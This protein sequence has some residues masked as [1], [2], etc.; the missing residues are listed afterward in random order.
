M[1]S[2]WNSPSY[3]A[4]STAS[5]MSTPTPYLQLRHLLSLTWLAY[6]ILSLIFIAFRLQ[7]SL[8]D[9]QNSIASAK[10]TLIASC[11]A[12]EEAATSA[13]SMPRFLALA[14]NKQ[15]ADAVNGSLNAARAALILSLTVMEAVINF[16]IDLYRSTFLCFVELVVKGALALV[17]A[18]VEE[19]NKVVGTIADGLATAIDTVLNPIINALNK[20]G[21][22]AAK[23]V[24]ID[25]NAIK[26]PNLDALH[27]VSLP[28]SFM[29][30][31]TKLSD[32]IPSV[33]DLKDKIED[34]IDTP[35]ELL[36]KDVND[37]FS[38]ISFDPDG[39]PVPEVA[40]VT[41]CGDL[42]TSV[43]D[44]LGRDL[45]K[46][47]KI[48]VVIII[49]LAL[50]L[51]ALNC[52][53]TWYK[54][55]C[56]RQHLQY[57]R[58]AWM[59]DP[60]IVHANSAS[61]PPQIVMSDHNLLMLHANSEHP[62]ITRITNVL[63][64]RLRLTPNNHA[65][66]QWFFNYVFHPPALA[67]FLIGFFGL[68]SVQIQLWALG[69]LVHKYQ[70][71][72]AS[73]TADYSAVIATAINQSMYNQSSSYADAVNGR[74]DS[75]QSAINNGLFGW[76]DGTTTTL[77]NTIN[78][79]YTDIQNV[80][81]TVFGGSP[82]E[83]PVNDFLKCFIGNK[84][85]AI[86]TA[87]TFL[88]DNL[89]IDVPR[90]NQT[91]L[92][93]SPESVNEATQPIAQAAIGGGAGDENGGGLIG[94]L[95]SS[96]AA[97][98]RKERIMFAIFMGLWGFVI[99]MAIAFI[100]WDAVGRPYLHERARKK[101]QLEQRGGIEAVGGTYQSSIG[102]EEKRDFN[103]FSP[104]PS[105]TGGEFKT[106]NA[107]FGNS[108]VDQH[109]HVQETAEKKR[110]PLKLL[111]LGRRAMQ[112]GERLKKDGSEE[113]VPLSP[114]QITEPVSANYRN[115]AWF[116]K[117]PGLLTRKNK[118][119]DDTYID[120]WSQQPPMQQP[121][122]A[123][124]KL[125][126]YTQR[127]ID[128]YGPPPRQQDWSNSQQ[129]EMHIPTVQVHEPGAPPYYAGIQPS[130]APTR[131]REQVTSIPQDVGPM[132]EG[133]TRPAAAAAAPPP[134]SAIF[135]IPLYTGF[136]S[137][138]SRNPPPRHPQ[139]QAEIERRQREKDAAAA[140]W[141]VT[142]GLPGDPVV[143]AD[144]QDMSR[145]H[146]RKSSTINPFITPFDDEHRVVVVDSAE[147]S[148]ARKSIQT[149]PFGDPL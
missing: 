120:S 69:P 12:A 42:D 66:T 148:A 117:M 28:Q 133:S 113:T 136:D 144:E 96:Y 141:R 146:A 46:M 24:G 114:T 34:V 138:E 112:R 41:F 56:M 94:R 104:L 131:S 97:S 92:V 89:H 20:A 32:S 85:D 45:I 43:V 137:H 14:T 35:F 123:R 77:N 72:A 91:V 71:R 39:L 51:I 93:L 98:L 44:D 116:G 143:S 27:N 79:F 10:D 18:A 105:P 57:T 106:E 58:E 142:N 101:Y 95:I 68:L 48:G 25:I 122:Q 59:T 23:L 8:A 30:S 26:P 33:A 36:K 87:L 109:G 67:C 108:S 88:H 47:A 82:L 107:A 99:L 140:R 81:T 83:D 60:T 65:R 9:A 38:Q 139:V 100:V 11:K 61:S 110:G 126:I 149:N 53:L 31:L 63:S 80:V 86:E 127:G 4:H 84:V 130:G 49:L 54:W 129:T 17:V 70:D 147:R 124:P 76:V 55:R 40:R 102:H 16:I 90:L 15:Y 75:M 62:L 22:T 5:Y 64:A 6:P 73:T 2:N 50:L 119:V 13:T 111:A 3:D 121:E 145:H 78:T 1:S 19:L 103:S 128:K 37:T 7:L 21:S 132:Y 134:P 115:T 135:P 29:D 74:V 125:Q 118:D 52:L